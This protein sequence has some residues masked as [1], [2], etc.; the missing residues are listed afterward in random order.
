MDAG[1]GNPNRQ[2]C[3]KT[4]L[5]PVQR[6][7]GGGQLPPNPEA[8][9]RIGAISV[10]CVPSTTRVNEYGQALA[11]PSLPSVFLVSASP[12]T[13]HRPWASPRA[14]TEEPLQ[15]P[16]MTAIAWLRELSSRS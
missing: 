4:S 9:G 13:S 1:S 5:R 2:V 11:A 14:T 15:D 10:A 12:T 6:T 8:Q 3:D 16:T 7:T